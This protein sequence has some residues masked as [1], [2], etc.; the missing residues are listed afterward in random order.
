[1]GKVKWGGVAVAVIAVIAIVALATQGLF[2][3]G[4]E[5]GETADKKG[6]AAPDRPDPAETADKRGTAAPDRPGPAGDDREAPGDVAKAPDRAADADDQQTGAGAASGANDEPDRDDVSPAAEDGPGD[7]SRQAADTEIDE[8]A[9]SEVPAT[10][11]DAAAPDDETG[12]ALQAEAESYVQQLAEPS[13]EP[14]QM[15]SAEGFVGGDRALT[16]APPE[17]GTPGA[18]QPEADEVG[19][20]DE[21]GAADEPVVQ[22]ESLPAGAQSAAQPETPAEAGGDPVRPRTA[23][24]ETRDAPE[25]DAPEAAADEPRQARVDLPLSEEAP[26]TIAE[27][28][29][30]EESIASDAVFYVHTVRP[31]DSQGIWGIV[32]DGIV[33][34]FAEG[35]A[36]HRGES[37]ETYRVDIPP[38]ADEREPDSSSSFLGRIIHEKSQQTYVYNYQT[39]RLGRNPDLIFPGQEIVIV[40]FTPDELIEIYKYFARAGGERSG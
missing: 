11:S 17:G 35:V 1:M 39:E 6:T 24:A 13:D 40:S 33:E 26:V 30:A 18:A 9:V 28:L 12:E 15:E 27:L 36:V 3:T 19:Q 34:N 8:T 37:T 38:H 32:H 7:V 10:G 2:T 23:A 4:S 21:A 22:P 20:V 25:S 29:G 31:E 14:V 5:P 16:T